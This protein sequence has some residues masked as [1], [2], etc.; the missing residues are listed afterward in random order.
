MN[1]KPIGEYDV[2][3]VSHRYFNTRYVGEN[4]KSEYLSV[5]WNSVRNRKKPIIFGDRTPRR[6]FKYVE[7]PARVFVLAMKIGSWRNL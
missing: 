1:T 4:S 6:E 5:N 7:D 3:A 2:E